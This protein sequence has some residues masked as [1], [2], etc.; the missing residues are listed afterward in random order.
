MN[1]SATSYELHVVVSLDVVVLLDYMSLFR[2]DNATTT[3]HF[4][5]LVETAKL[6]T[7]S[8]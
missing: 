6:Q 2:S 1:L 5:T 3:T 7:D 4:P 8:I